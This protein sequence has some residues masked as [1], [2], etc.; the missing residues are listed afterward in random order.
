ME[1]SIII[2]L[3]FAI[4]I[5]L[6]L[7][8]VYCWYGKINKSIKIQEESLGVQY[9]ILEHLRKNE[10]AKTPIVEPERLES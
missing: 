2:G 7:R 5:L 10:T 4:L 1:S 3:F 9:R 8:E 6:A